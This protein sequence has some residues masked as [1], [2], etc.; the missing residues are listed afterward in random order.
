MEIVG[1]IGAILFS[2]CAVPQAYTSWKQKHSDGLSWYF[3][4]MWFFG[5]VLTL[6]YVF[7]TFQWPLIFNYLFNMA[8]LLVILWY[9]FFDEK[10][11]LSEQL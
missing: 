4:S 7:P 8:C 1:W 9:R 6:I 2:F 5:E 10:E 3:L 11:T